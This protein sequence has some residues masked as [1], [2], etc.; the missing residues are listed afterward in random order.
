MDDKKE[1]FAVYA[2][3]EFYYDNFPKEMS[4]TWSYNEKLSEKDITYFY[5]WVQGKNLED[6]CPEHLKYR[7][8]AAEK[9][10][11][12]HFNS[13]RNA[14]INLDD[15]CFYDLV[16]DKHLLSYFECRN[17]ICEWIRDNHAKPSNYRFLHDTYR[18]IQ[19]ISSRKLNINKHKLYNYKNTDF[20]ARTLWKNF[21]EKDKIFINYDLF[22][23]VTGR[24]T[25]K[26]GSFPI[27]NIKSELK[28]IVRPTNDVFI[29]LDFNAAEI[30]T[31][32]SLSEQK[33]PQED[34]HEFNR[35]TIFRKGT[36]EEAKTRF[37]AWLYN[38][39]S[40]AIQSDF[41]SREDVLEKHYR[42]GAV[43]TPFG[44]KLECDRFHA[45]NYLLQS[46]SSDNCMD[47]VNKINKFLKG[48]KS[49][50]AFTVHDCVI[51]DLSFEDRYLI[52]QVKEIFED[53]KLG[54]FVSSMHIG[55]DLKNME[56][57]QC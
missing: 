23:S 33:Q 29:E 42:E 44:R 56:E 27:M 1:C 49:H 21:G 4:H 55:K 41:Y 2:K 20:K 10:I 8:N 34:I 46:T 43:W 38:D 28:D 40:K 18:T 26:P 54:H 11:K 51:I 24:L 25:T 12:G 3:G 6:V 19:D 36:R 57:L 52:P 14:M 15:V 47:R 50:V 37:F 9:K 31:L 30:R 35:K 22:G 53:T 48:T 45:L 17:E 13:F 16:P 32:I 5:L 7:Y 39:R